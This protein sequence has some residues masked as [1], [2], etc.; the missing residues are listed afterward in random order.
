MEEKTREFV[1]YNA[2]NYISFYALRMLFR[3]SLFIHSII[4]VVGIYAINTFGV[5]WRTLFP[6]FAAVIWCLLYLIF[7]C[8]VARAKKTF[9]LRFL[10]NGISGLFVSSLVWLLVSSFGVMQE[11]EEKPYGFDF[12][13]WVLFFYIIFSVIYVF[14]IVSGV[15]KGVYKKAKGEIQKTK[16]FDGASLHAAIIP[17]VGLICVYIS[18]MLRG[19]V[20]KN[21]KD[22]FFMI[23]FV[24]L[25]FI[26]AEAN[27]YFVQYF[28]CKKCK[29][30]C[31]EN[32]NTSSPGLYG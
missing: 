9:E 15:H 16:A 32:G 6:I 11:Y 18:E 30:F 3:V 5:T 4:M 20:S 21:A 2:D 25:M 10:V 22:I 26:F 29:I 31:D 24:V 19:D 23:G 7:I 27:M 12:C 13:L 14:L 8:K 17:A 1:Y 28:Y